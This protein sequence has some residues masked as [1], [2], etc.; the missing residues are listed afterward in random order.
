MCTSPPIVH[1]PVRNLLLLRLA[2][3]ALALHA[4]APRHHAGNLLCLAEAL[5]RV[6]VLARG[7]HRVQPVGLVLFTG[8]SPGC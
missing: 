5:G 6:A 7:L 1:Q 3:L 4:L 2:L 8:G